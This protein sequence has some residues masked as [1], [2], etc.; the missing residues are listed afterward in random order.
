MNQKKISQK[1]KYQER[2]RP[3]NDPSPM[4]YTQLLPILVNAGAI[5]PK[6]TRPSRFPYDRKHDPHAI[7]GYHVEHV[8]NSIENC[9]SFKTKVQELID[10]K[11]LSFTPIIT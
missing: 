8:G 1:N 5:V 4:S 11:L 10:Q 3:R 2:R 6:Q 9:Y 7:C